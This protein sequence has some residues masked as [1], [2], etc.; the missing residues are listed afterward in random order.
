M[1]QPCPESVCDVHN[2]CQHLNKMGCG[3]ETAWLAV[4]LFVR[5]LVQH[6]SLFS[7]AGKQTMQ[8]L[9]FDALA[10]RDPSVEH[11][12]HVVR[13]LEEHLTDNAR[14][15][16]LQEA[17]ES[18]KAAADS[19]A[20][21]VSDFLK[22]SLES[23]QERGRLLRHF[24]KDAMDTL[25][26]GDDHAVMLPRLRTL[27]TEMLAHY[28]EEAKTWERKAAALEQAMLVDPLLTPLHNRRA[29]DEHLRQALDAAD[30]DGRPLS[31]LM[32]DV[33][34]FKTAVNDA[35]GHTVGDDVLRTLAKIVGGHAARHGW[36]AARYGG[37]ELILVAPLDGEAASIQAEAIRLAVARYEFR[38]RIDGRL[39]EAAIHFTVSI[40]VAAYAPGMTA[41]E[42]VDAADRAMYRVKGTGRNNVAR[43]ASL[44]AG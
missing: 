11:L 20:E 1:E 36:F 3:R 40:G 35:Y 42:L 23:E 14:T 17:L 39:T 34:R 28:R 9:V 27:V 18:E 33:D 5:D 24:G 38:P 10:R 16:A 6:F 2:L 19:L 22:D 41:R 32:I 30:R 21:S 4:T 31:V 43:F 13:R 25:G 37:D 8:Q 7:D 15:A 12:Q 44:G 29:L 26:S